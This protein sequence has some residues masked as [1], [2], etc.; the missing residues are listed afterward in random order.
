MT[1]KTGKKGRFKSK[2]ASILEGQGS[3]PMTME[4]F[5]DGEVGKGASE[6][7]PKLEGRQTEK[8][9]LTQNRKSSNAQDHIRAEP[10]ESNGSNL[11]VAG[12]KEP[13]SYKKTNA[14]HVER[15][16][17]QIRKDLADRLLEIAYH[18]RSS[19]MK[20]REATQKAIIEAALEDY[21]RKNDKVKLR[22]NR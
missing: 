5:L 14:E 13:P 22:L 7:V 11:R 17:V 3:V 6:D 12:T 18:M 8:T 2:G 1:G 10:H 15:L 19:G 16:H 20:R 9:G 4:E 21:F